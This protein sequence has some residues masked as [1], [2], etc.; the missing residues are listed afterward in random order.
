MSSKTPFI[1]RHGI[2]F[3]ALFV[4]LGGTSYAMSGATFVSPQ[5]AVSACVK[6]SG[7]LK[8]VAP[9]TKCHKTQQLVRWNL[10]G[11]SG[12]SGGT[13]ATGASGTNGTNG[14]NGANGASLG[15]NDF[16]DGPTAISTNGEV[17]VA[18]LSNVPAG[19][20]IVTAKVQLEGGT[21]AVLMDCFLRAGVDFDES[22]T[23]LQIQTG[24]NAYEETLP[25]T[26]SHTFAAAGAITLTCNG[27][28]ANYTAANAKISAVQVQSLTRTSG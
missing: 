23:L 24:T 12:K 4:A 22:R 8:L 14:A 5:G 2:A 7:T 26:L 25:F 20:Y 6:K 17:A 19:N 21:L 10:Q 1:R 16:N 13:G 15:L 28:G 11:V 9:G 18:T 3:V 27:F